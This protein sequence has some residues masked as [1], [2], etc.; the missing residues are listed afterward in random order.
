MEDC[1]S[2]DQEIDSGSNSQGFN[3][4]EDL[5]FSPDLDLLQNEGNRKEDRHTD[6]INEASE[7]S[8]E[9][10]NGIAS[11]TDRDLNE[12][13]LQHLSISP[14]REQNQRIIEEDELLSTSLNKMITANNRGR[15]RKYHK[16]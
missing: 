11:L 16:R 14:A 13:S 4:D 15:K 3:T 5:E 8:W 10:I 7:V 9:N 12:K 6:T 2:L 1:I